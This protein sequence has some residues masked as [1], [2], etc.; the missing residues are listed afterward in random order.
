MK[1]VC[2]HCNEETTPAKKSVLN[3]DFSRCEKIFCVLCGG[4][5]DDE[6]ADSG[7]ERFAALLGVELEAA[8]TLPDGEAPR[9]CRDCANYV[10]HPF[11]SRC[12]LHNR[13]VDPM[14]DCTAFAPR[15]EQKGKI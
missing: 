13:G 15:I 3:D 14:E 2:P 6:V 9:F 7:K 10:V 5:L 8:P 1:Q 11:L 4:E 12:S